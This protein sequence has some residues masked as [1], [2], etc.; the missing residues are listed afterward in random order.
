MR[1]REARVL[2]DSTAEVARRTHQV[3]GPAHAPEVTTTEVEVVRFGV[4][5]AATRSRNLRRGRA[6]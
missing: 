3:F 1:P 4:L 5:G 6:A 2:L